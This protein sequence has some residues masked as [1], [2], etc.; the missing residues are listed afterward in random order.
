MKKPAQRKPAPA[1]ATATERFELRL[2][3]A[4]KAK[5]MRLG[6]SEWVRERVRAAKESRA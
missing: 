2:T 3:P 1:N 4:D 6:G 5:L